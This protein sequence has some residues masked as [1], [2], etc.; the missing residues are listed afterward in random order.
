MGNIAVVAHKYLPQPDDDLIDF[1][2]I[3]KKSRVLHIKH[4]F[5]DAS[6]RCSSYSLYSKG[7]KIKEKTSVD[8]RF[9]PEVLVYIKELFFTIKWIVFSKTK[10]DLYIGMDSLCV[11]FGLILRSIGSCKK[12]IFW[13]I[14]FVPQGRFKQSWKNLVYRNID[15]LACK[16]ADEVWNLSPKMA[17]GRKKFLGLDNKDYKF[18]KIV[19]YGVWTER[20]KKVCYSK[21]QKNTLV[22]MGHLLPK[23]GVDMVIAKIPEIVKRIPEFKFKIIGG[24]SYEEKLINLAKNLSVDK[25]CLFRG[26]IEDNR[27]LEDEVAKSAVAIAPYLKTPNSYTY[28]ADS[29]K[30]KTYLACG[31]P[32]LLIDLPWNAKE[33]QQ[34]KCGLIINGYGKDLVEKLLKIMKPS[35]NREFR[36]NAVKYS[37][38]FDYE[39][40]F[41]ELKL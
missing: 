34:E 6:D 39:K 25:Y 15:I 2:N 4:S 37:K 17:E 40:I 16:S 38:N 24:G 18:R 9:L 3:K 23:Q 7:S 35:L 13:S 20:I 8:Y 19:S 31:V 26:R 21:C 1:L 41:S 12:V 33:I 27:V 29:G 28:Y 10:W 11:F 14:D 22:F 30:I 32:V 36:K 5:P